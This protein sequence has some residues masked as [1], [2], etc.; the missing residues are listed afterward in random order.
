M[1]EKGKTICLDA[2]TGETVFEEELDDFDGLLYASVLVADGK[3]YAPTQDV[4]TY[5]IEAKPKFKLLAIN[6]FK[7]DSER[8]NAS[9]AVSGNALIM[10]TDK[11]VYSI[12]N[13]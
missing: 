12:V 9:I 7:D 10:R 13:K 4:G 6:K 8:V 5:V 2:K 11:A 1:H 3:L